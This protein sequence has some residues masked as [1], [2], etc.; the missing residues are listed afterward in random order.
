MKDLVIAVVGDQSLHHRWIKEEREFDL[1]II[2]YGD[3]EGKYANDGEYYMDEKGIKFELI[4]EAL[5]QYNLIHKYGYF[6]MPD[7][8]LWATTDDIHKFCGL[9][10]EHQL[11]LSQPSIIGYYSWAL[12]LHNPYYILRYTNRVENMTPCFNQHALRICLHSFTENRS[13]WGLGMLWDKLLNHPINEIGII[14]DVTFIHTREAK[15]K[16][17]YDNYTDFD[18]HEDKKRLMEKYELVNERKIYWE[19]SIPKSFHEMEHKNSSKKIYP[20]SQALQE[21]LPQLRRQK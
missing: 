17:L 4:H 14:D 1:F 3:E 15:Q 10:K 16:C 12:T 21:W 5:I 2:Y 11:L 6:L 13:G 9:I 20:N 8:D 19:T 18:P 7:D